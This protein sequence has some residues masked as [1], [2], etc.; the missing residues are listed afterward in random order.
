[1]QVGRSVSVHNT[2]GFASCTTGI[3]QSHG[4][5]LVELWPVKTAG[6]IFYKIFVVNDVCES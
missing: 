3:A 1:M 5:V 4:C 6:L 2:F